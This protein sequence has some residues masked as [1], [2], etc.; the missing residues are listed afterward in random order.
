MFRYRPGWLND[1]LSDLKKLTYYS[2]KCSCRLIRLCRLITA[3][4]YN[5]PDNDWR[6]IPD[7]AIDELAHAGG[8]GGWQCVCDWPEISVL[9]TCGHQL[10]WSASI[11]NNVAAGSGL[12]LAAKYQQ[13]Q[14]RWRPA[15][16]RE[17]KRLCSAKTG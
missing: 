16:R 15:I 8:G 7:N 11:R 12:A 4:E 10:C 2:A 17:H 3:E 6:T 14:P 9:K 5:Q 13:R 1:V